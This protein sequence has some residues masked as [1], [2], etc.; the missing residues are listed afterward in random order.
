MVVY[1]NVE[2]KVQN[3]SQALSGWLPRKLSLVAYFRR[4]EPVPSRRKSTRR[5]SQNSFTIAIMCF[6]MVITTTF[7]TMSVV[8]MCIA[9]II[10]IS[11]ITCYH[12][13]H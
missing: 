10:I 8:I 1:V 13:Y 3:T 7:T 11:I 9:I 6:I 4:S 5:Q 12:R 2:L